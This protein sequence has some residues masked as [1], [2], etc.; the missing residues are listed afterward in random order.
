[1]VC[2]MTAAFGR[3]NRAPAPR[4]AK[5]APSRK[6]S[7]APAAELVLTEAQRAY[8]F[9]G[10]E[11]ERAADWA[12]AETSSRPGSNRRAGLIACAA[13]T[14][15]TVALSSIGKH[16]GGLAGVPAAIEPMTHDFLGLIGSSAGAFVLAWSVLI[17]FVNFSANLWLTRKLTAAFDLSA[18]PAYAGIGALLGLTV[19]WISAALGLGASD[20]GLGMEALAGAGVAGL[21][22]LLSGPR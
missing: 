20:I 22:R 14:S 3:R 9:A 6:T 21:Y 7:S 13:M 5:P 1:M 2:V 8:L 4:S 10:D 11:R 16:D 17:Y 18:P 19:A 15:V 12:P